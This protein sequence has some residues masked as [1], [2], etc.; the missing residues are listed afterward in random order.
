LEQHQELFAAT[1]YAVQSSVPGAAF[2]L[3]VE[4]VKTQRK[5]T[6]TQAN[7]VPL[8]FLS[9]E[10]RFQSHHSSCPPLCVLAGWAVF[11]FM[12]LQ[13]RLH[14]KSFKLAL[15]QRG[16]AHSQNRNSHVPNHPA[17]VCVLA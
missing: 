3:F 12:S 4:S 7:T 13:C 2:D 17:L 9:K 15:S 10:F 5:I 8:W 6:V 11:R 1:T 14:C 16:K